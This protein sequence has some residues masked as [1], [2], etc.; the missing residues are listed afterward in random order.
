M[1]NDSLYKVYLADPFGCVSADA[2]LKINIALQNYFNQIVGAKGSGFSSALVHWLAYFP[3]PQPYELMLYYLP[4]RSVSAAAELGATPAQDTDGTTYWKA[5]GPAVS[6]VYKGSG[7]AIGLANLG[8]HELMHN[9]LRLN[10]AQLHPKNGM[11]GAIVTASTK[12][13][14]G[15]IA[16]MAAALK[17]DAPQYTSAF[18]SMVQGRNDPMSRYYTP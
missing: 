9:K 18:S 14:P 12:L 10:D 16:D 6:E 2:K 13:S 17:K 8:M 11:A 4:S 1:S 15:N 3:T 5:G 7:D